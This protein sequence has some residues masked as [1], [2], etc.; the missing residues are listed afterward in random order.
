MIPLFHYYEPETSHIVA[1]IDP[2]A[3]LICS[4]ENTFCTGASRQAALLM[5][6]GTYSEGF[7][8][9]TASSGL[10]GQEEHFY[11]FNFSAALQIIGAFELSVG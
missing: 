11:T 8:T 7:W 1:S 6:S 4:S 10:Q 2:L 5:D 3:L 9:W